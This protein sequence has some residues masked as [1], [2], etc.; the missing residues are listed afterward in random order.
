MEKVGQI[1]VEDSMRRSE[2]KNS[3]HKLLI[4]ISRENDIEQEH[5]RHNKERNHE[6]TRTERTRRRY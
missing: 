2:D 5:R 6:R 4:M 1:E 3:T